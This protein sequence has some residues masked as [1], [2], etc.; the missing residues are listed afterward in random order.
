VLCLD[1]SDQVNGESDLLL[2]EVGGEE[3][4]ES[5]LWFEIEVDLHHIHYGFHEVVIIL[6]VQYVSLLFN[7][8]SNKLRI[9]KH[10]VM[11]Y[12]QIHR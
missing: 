2:D 4:V 12:G 9:H 5:E 7:E 3:L 10:T 8:L 6:C 11:E 1:G